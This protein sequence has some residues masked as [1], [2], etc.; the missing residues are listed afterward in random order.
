[1]ELTIF[2]SDKGDCLLLTGGSG[3][4]MLVDGGMR[5]AYRGHVAPR[6]AD[7]A[8]EGGQLEV[9]YV[10]HIDEDHIAG[11]LQLADDLLAWKIYDHVHG[12]G[13]ESFPEPE[14]QRPPPVGEIWHNGF[15]EQVGDNATDIEALLL[16]TAA[17]LS[18]HPDADMRGLASAQRELAT[19]ERQ[20]VLLQ[21]RLGAQ[22]L[23]IPLN[24]PAQGQ[25]M[26]VREE[27]TPITV[28]SLRVSIVGPFR[29]DLENLRTRWNRWL[30][31]AKGAKDLA[32]VRR[33][34]EE[35]ED[36]LRS[37]ELSRFMR[38][39]EAE[40]KALGNRAEVTVPNLAS[41]ML[42]VEDDGRTLLLTGD[43]HA[44]DLLR[45]LWRLGV[46]DEDTG[47]LHLSV[48]KVPHHGA[49]ANTTD[50]FVTLVT[51]DHYVFC[52][53]GEHENP[54]LTVV[55]R[56]IDSR[57]GRTEQR[58]RNPE[59]DQPFT[60]WFSSSAA[61]PGLKP[62]NVEHMAAVE[63]LVAEHA[64]ASGGRLRAMFLTDAPLVLAL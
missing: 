24:P 12:Q 13:D 28:G 42:L 27:N 64:Q 63:R 47:G 48:C 58:S 2:P 21:R 60:L 62:G 8:A 53:N 36:L 32:G 38:G 18:G 4:R 54:E 14:V 9:V 61:F 52:G 6:L 11:V 19:S 10:S 31:S 56:I 25:L 45:G 44:D 23:G 17:I 20:A 5:P 3:A 57:L 39:L 34:A 1:M 40:A 51:A 16:E 35:K 29:E 15:H 33:D 30:E 59:A 55:R 50:E 22:Q 7:L 49:T 43:G 26:M 41:L 37:N 46:M